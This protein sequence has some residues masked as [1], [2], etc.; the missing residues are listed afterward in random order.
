MNNLS[1][2]L[3]EFEPRIAEIY[4]NFVNYTYDDLSERFGK[5]FKGISNSY[6]YSTYK[7]ML[8]PVLTSNVSNGRITECFIHPVLLKEVSEKY[9]ELTVKEYEA[10]IIGKLQDIQDIVVERLLNDEFQITGTRN[11]NKILLEQRIVF[12]TSSKGLPF[13]QFPARIYVNGK[14]LSEKKYKEMFA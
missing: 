10:K 5:T 4:C 11:G 7:N 6:S 8:K 12:K 14:F 13:N 3:K 1:K 2:A 9:A